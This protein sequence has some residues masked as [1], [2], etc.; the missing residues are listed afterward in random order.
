MKK[1]FFLFLSLGLLG[2]IV[3][4]FLS[5]HSKNLSDYEYGYNQKRRVSTK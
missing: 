3:F 4:L 2:V 5:F 1:S